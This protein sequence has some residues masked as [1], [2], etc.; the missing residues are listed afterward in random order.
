LDRGQLREANGYYVSLSAGTSG[1]LAAV[2]QYIEKNAN[3][4]NDIASYLKANSDETN[5]SSSVAA[6]FQVI[7]TEEE[8]ISTSTGLPLTVG[9]LQKRLDTHKAS[10]EKKLEEIAA[11]NIDPALYSIDR[12]KHSAGTS[13]ATELDAESTQLSQ[14]DAA[15]KPTESLSAIT[16]DPNKMRIPLNRRFKPVASCS[17]LP[18]EPASRQRPRASLS[19]LLHQDVKGAFAPSRLVSF[20]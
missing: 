18:S 19:L 17:T 13:K 9:L 6:L 8:R 12:S 4:E 1:Q 5:T 10:L 15:L 20:G 14:L 2:S 16:N 11:L 7:A 3:F